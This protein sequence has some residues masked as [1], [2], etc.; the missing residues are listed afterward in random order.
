MSGAFLM[1][2]EEKSAFRLEARA[3]A[4]PLVGARV[5]RFSFPGRAASMVFH[6]ALAAHLA[7]AILA[8]SSV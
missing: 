4:S 5:A 6:R 1:P 7:N 2:D 8:W 3:V